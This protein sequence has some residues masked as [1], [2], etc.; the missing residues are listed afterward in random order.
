MASAG[1]EGNRIGP[2]RSADR[3][4]SL[5]DLSAHAG[6][7]GGESRPVASR[8]RRSTAVVAATLAQGRT[9]GSIDLH[10][11]YRFGDHDLEIHRSIP[12]N[13]RNF[14]RLRRR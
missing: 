11:L 7:A 13:H 8:A 2:R 12:T 9:T 14:H 10:P 1:L 4:P 6:G 5:R 3:P